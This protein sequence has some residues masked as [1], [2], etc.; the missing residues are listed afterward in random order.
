MIECPTGCATCTAANACGTCKTGFF[1][2]G[3]VCSRNFLLQTVNF[4]GK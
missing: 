4:I 1:P 3:G 2:N